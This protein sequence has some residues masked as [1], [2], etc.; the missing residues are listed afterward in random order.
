MIY[1]NDLAKQFVFMTS[2][3]RVT[4]M[5]RSHQLGQI[6]KRLAAL[7]NDLIKRIG[8]TNCADD[9]LVLSLEKSLVCLI[10]ELINRHTKCS[11]PFTHIVVQLSWKKKTISIRNSLKVECQLTLNRRWR[12]LNHF[13]VRI[14]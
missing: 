13:D 8:W 5:R 10:R 12:N 14:P 3:I 11:A 2:K 4:S 7:I 9:D 6:L 1:V